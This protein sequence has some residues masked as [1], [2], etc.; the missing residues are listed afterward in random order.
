M[1]GTEISEFQGLPSMVDLDQLFL[2]I[3]R[4]SDKNKE[5][6]KEKSLSSCF[7]CFP[8]YQVSGEP[9]VGSQFQNLD[10]PFLVFL[11]CKCLLQASE[12]QR[13]QFFS[14]PSQMTLS[15]PVVSQP[16]QGYQQATKTKPHG[17]IVPLS[18]RECLSC[19]APC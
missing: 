9:W 2:F 11:D 12:L 17:T 8:L 1:L 15:P 14:C 6:K 4:V 3:S 19:L 10:I 7:S 5:R 16:G 18:H 13:P